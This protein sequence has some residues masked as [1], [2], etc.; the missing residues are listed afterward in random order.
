MTIYH[1]ASHQMTMI[2]CQLAALN[3]LSLTVSQLHITRRAS[4]HGLWQY[5]ICMTPQRGFIR[6][7]T[8]HPLLTWYI[9]ISLLL[10][11][12]SISID[13]LTKPGAS[14]SHVCANDKLWA[15]INDWHIISHIIWATIWLMNFTQN[16]FFIYC[17]M[18]IC[19]G[20]YF[21]IHLISFNPRIYTYI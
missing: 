12:Y 7:W 11:I 19:D 17:V 13:A 14:I 21:F 18:L 16:N 9:V 20:I 8:T 2:I 10:A 3:I 4:L 5:T 6:E 15:Y 1:D